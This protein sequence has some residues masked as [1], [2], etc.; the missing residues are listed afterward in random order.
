MIVKAMTTNNMGSFYVHGVLRDV[1]TAKERVHVFRKDRSLTVS[2]RI[3]AGDVVRPK[4]EQTPPKLHVLLKYTSQPQYTLLYPHLPL[5]LSPWGPPPS[6]QHPHE[7]TYATQPYFK[8]LRG[9]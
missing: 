3:N 8:Y 7:G 9:L 1:H 6:F 5:D 4:H 2:T